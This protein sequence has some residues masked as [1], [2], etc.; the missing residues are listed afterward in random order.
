MAVIRA[1]G[2]F[3]GAHV[4]SGVYHTVVS[5]ERGSIFFEA[6]AGP[7]EVLTDKDFAPWSPPERNPDAA[8]YLEKLRALFR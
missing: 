7:Y 3:V 6:K 2:D 1:G 4:P 8:A 5:L